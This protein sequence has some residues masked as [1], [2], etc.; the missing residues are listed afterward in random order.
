MWYMAAWVT[1]VENIGIKAQIA[2]INRT[3]RKGEIWAFQG[4]FIEDSSLVRSRDMT[5][6]VWKSLFW[7]FHQIDNKSWFLAP[8]PSYLGSR[9]GQKLQWKLPEKLRF[10]SFR[11]FYSFW[12]F[13]PKN[14][15]FLRRSLMPPF[16]HI[17][18]Q[19]DLIKW[20]IFFW[21]FGN[22]WKFSGPNVLCLG[23]SEVSSDQKY[24]D[25]VRN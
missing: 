24:L 8:K 19:T 18:V 10:H 14:L 9:Q 1:F 5:I 23:I 3:I 6:L 7:T 22:F 4:A 20:C 11:W 25:L 15:F 12:L 17:Y 16:H 21:D 13:D 2:Q